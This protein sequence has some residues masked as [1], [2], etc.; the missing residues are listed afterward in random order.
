[1][2]AGRQAGRQVEE[3]S[4]TEEPVE[5]ME[6]RVGR[7]PSVRRRSE[8]GRKIIGVTMDPAEK[9][10]SHGTLSKRA[11]IGNLKTPEN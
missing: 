1:M 9:R 10:Y 11:N 2:R 3:T 7:V 8:D 5:D 4:A 6:G